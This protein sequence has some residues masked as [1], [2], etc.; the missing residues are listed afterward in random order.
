MDV[1]RMIVTDPDLPLDQRGPLAGPYKSN[2]VDPQLES[3]WFQPSSRKSEK[4]VSKFVFSN[5]TL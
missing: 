3:A 2:A 4:L 5:S 1:L